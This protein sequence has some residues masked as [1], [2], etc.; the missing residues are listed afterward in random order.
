MDWWNWNTLILSLNNGVVLALER[1]AV[2]NRLLLRWSGLSLSEGF[3]ITMVGLHMSGDIPTINCA[4][5]L[6][7]E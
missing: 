3:V 2:W 6:A 5:I 4:T 1:C 7:L